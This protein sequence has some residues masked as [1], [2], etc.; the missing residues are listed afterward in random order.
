MMSSAPFKLKQIACIKQRAVILQQVA[1]SEGYTD[2]Q[3]ANR[4]KVVQNIE[5]D[6]L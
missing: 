4:E 6:S 3:P 1:K 2:F 5:R